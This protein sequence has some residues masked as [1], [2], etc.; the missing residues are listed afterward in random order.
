M[1]PGFYTVCVFGRN[2]DKMKFSSCALHNIESAESWKN[3]MNKEELSKPKAQQKQHFV[4][5]IHQD[6]PD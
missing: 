4:I 6:Q 1:I 2:Y 3:F 5:Q